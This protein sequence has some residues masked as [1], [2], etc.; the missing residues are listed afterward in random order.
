MKQHN[1]FQYWLKWDVN[2]GWDVVGVYLY[3]WCNVVGPFARQQRYPTKR[4]PSP[5]PAASKKQLTVQ[6]VSRHPF[7]AIY[8]SMHRLRT[9]FTRSRTPT[10]AEMKTQSSLEVPKQ[11]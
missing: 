6:C 5:S 7:S 2:H 9:T 8:C 10:G 1:Q 11:V 4:P 3:S